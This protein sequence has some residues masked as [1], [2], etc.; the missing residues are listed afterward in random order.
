M[1][2]DL[3]G[4]LVTTGD[5]KLA[6]LDGRQFRRDT[7][8][9][10][11]LR[12]KRGAYVDGAVWN[13]LTLQKRHRLTV[14]AFA[15]SHC[16]AVFSH[17][18]A[19]ALHGLPVIGPWPDEVQVAAPR[20]TGGRSEPGIRRHCRGLPEAD[21]VLIEG[22]PVT[23]VLRTLV[24]LASV[25]PF[26]ASVAA[27]DQALRV[28]MVTRAELLDYVMETAK[29]RGRV[30]AIRA[31]EFGNPLAANPGESMSRAVIHELGFAPPALQVRHP[32]S[33]R[34][35]DYADFEWLE[36]NTIGEF[37][38]LIKYFDPQYMSGRSSSEVV[39][40]EKRREDRLRAQAG[41]FARW[42]WDDAWR[43]EPLRRILLAA[44]LRPVRA[45]AAVTRAWH[46]DRA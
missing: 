15:E 23:S 30:A 14:H 1:Y 41:H 28:G 43:I 2:D 4:V 44:G 17:Q 42:N 39:Y 36:D 13:D 26:R 22:I 8:K 18:S 29:F 9:G 33:D 37:D 21:V 6:G 7:A 10:T 32:R 16:G 25:L 31:I 34:F 19:A 27:V 45:V 5:L 46:A 20:A 12:I 40:D 3:R 38:G 35:D 24:D 11:I